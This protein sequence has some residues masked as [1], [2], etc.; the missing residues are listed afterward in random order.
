M[1]FIEEVL[2]IHDR[3]IQ[4]YGGSYG[5]RDESMLKSAIERTYQTF[6][7]IDLYPDAISKAA[8][9]IESI[10]MNHPFVDGNKR[11]GFALM[12]LILVNANYS[13][14]VEDDEIYNFVIAIAS[15][16]MRYEEILI[17]LQENTKTI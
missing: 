10:L 5:L 7:G 8:A 17:W 9:I 15:G 4:R 11:T 3:G 14:S 16:E 12:L 13:I 1:I 6:S 2:L